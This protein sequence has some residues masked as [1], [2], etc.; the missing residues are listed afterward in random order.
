MYVCIYIHICTHTYIYR[1]N[2]SF[3]CRYVTFVEGYA[4]GPDGAPLEPDE[5]RS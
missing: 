1:V 2:P 3:I 4:T 5:V